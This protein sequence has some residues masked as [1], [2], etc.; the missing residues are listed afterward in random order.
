MQ[1]TLQSEAPV[2]E[3]CDELERLLGAVARPAALECAPRVGTLVAF[4]DP[5]TPLV[6]IGDGPARPARTT[7]DLLP[8]HIG[9]D[10]LLAF[11]GGAPD[12]PIVIGRVRAAP[13]W[14]TR[15]APP[16]VEVDADGR[17][18][19]VAVKEQLV[20]RCGL[21]SITLTAAGKV[22]IQGTYVSSRSS[23]VNRIKGGSVQ[24]N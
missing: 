5:C 8:E 11:E 2:D 21:A 13:A 24:I 9:A 19:T 4:A 17:R 16:Q 10:V 3:A 14:P 22:L 18:L 12:R 15:E 23:G 6:A 7:V 1:E 20:L